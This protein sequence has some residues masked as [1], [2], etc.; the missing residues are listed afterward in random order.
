MYNYTSLGKLDQEVATFEPSDNLLINGQPLNSLVEGYRHLTVTGRGLLGRN[1]STTKVPGRRGVWVDG[2]SD[3]ERTLEIKYQLKADTS[4]QMR[5]RF[6]KL[7]KILRT[8]AQSG[9]LEI[10]FRDEPEYIYYGYFNGAD[11]FEETSLSIV[12]KFNLL[13]P[14]G[15]KKKRPQNSTG[16]ISLVDAVEVLPESITVTPSKTTDRVQI[17]NG[18]KIISFSG[19]Y[20]PGKDIVISFDPDEVKATYGGRN[21]LSELDRF[22]PLELFKVRNGD[23]IT[24]VNAVVKKVVW[25][26][27]RA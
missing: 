22:S 3:E 16:P 2:F 17:V 4:A 15:Y 27:E 6:A 26:D 10:S 24:A 5:D 12:S 7:N 23:T 21:I 11:S 14:D 1:V 13:I 9:F 18:S 19:N 25:R 8:H 20:A